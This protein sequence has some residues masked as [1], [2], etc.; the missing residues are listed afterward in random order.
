MQEC[1]QRF[2]R[3]Y[4]PELRREPG[5]TESTAN[6]FKDIEPKV[7]LV[8]FMNLKLIKGNIKK[9]QQVYIK[10]MP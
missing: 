9:P 2:A 1:S 3:E 7:P 5:F 8:N 6:S 4:L 10:P